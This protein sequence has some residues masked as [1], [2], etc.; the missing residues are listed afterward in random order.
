[1]AIVKSNV[2]INLSKLSI[3]FGDLI[4]INKGKIYTHYNETE[5]K[6]Y[7]KNPA[8]NISI[9]VGNGKKSFIV[10]TMDLTK[11]YININTDYRS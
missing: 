3:K 1:M 5:V 2:D 11:E 6:N 9:D 8:I 4:I 7:M 10:Y